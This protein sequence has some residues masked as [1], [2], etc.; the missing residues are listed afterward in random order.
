MFVKYV[1]KM[2]FSGGNFFI[3]NNFFIFFSKIGGKIIKTKF[4]LFLFT[5]N[6]KIASPDVVNKD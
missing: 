6:R 5:Q 1:Y 4:Q 3:F 2:D